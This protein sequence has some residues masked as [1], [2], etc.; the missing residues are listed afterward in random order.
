MNNS[1]Q[2]NGYN[3]IT[4]INGKIYINGQEVNAKSL[5]FKNSMVMNN[6]KVY[7]NGKEKKNGKWKYT[8]KSI[9]NTL[10]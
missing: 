4:Q 10:F 1:F 3:T 7:I 6:N 9:F 2:T 8:L 5:F